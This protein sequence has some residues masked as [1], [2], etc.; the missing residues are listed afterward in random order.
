MT[1]TQQ[2]A[3]CAPQKALNVYQTLSSFWG[4]VRLTA[5][6]MTFTYKWNIVC[7]LGKSQELTPNLVPQPLYCTWACHEA[8]AQSPGPVPSTNV[9]WEQGL[10]IA[11]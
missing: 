11:L 9:R 1:I 6:A 7:C 8:I 4:W 3:S 5:R 2:A 10:G